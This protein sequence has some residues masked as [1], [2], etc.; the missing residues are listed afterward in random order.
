MRIYK[1]EPDE[2]LFHYCSA[3]TLMAVL[4]SGT[5]RFSDINMMNDSEEARWG[6]KVFEAAATRLIKRQDVG[7]D[8]PVMPK[9]FFDKVDEV[10]HAI[11]LIAHPFIA[12]FSRDADSLEQWRAYGDDG[13]GFVIGFSAKQLAQLPGTMFSVIY[14]VEDQV[15]EMMATLSVLFNDYQKLEAGG[16]VHAFRLLCADLGTMLCGLKHPS[17]KAE[18][19]VRCVHAIELQKTAKGGRRFVDPG[20]TRNGIEHKGEPVGF[21]VRDG[22]LTAY[23]DLP[24][25]TGDVSPV[26]AVI[27]GPKNHSAPGNLLLYLASVGLDAIKFGRSDIPY[28]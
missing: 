8:V 27:I 20:G 22:H 3:Q 16:D 15:R 12:C 21:Y 11:Q 18:N 6:Y 14:D 4:G 28:R 9:D 25:Q 23:V 1:P 5:I 26:E 19:E 24:M 10:V 17:F 2:M 13:R 7:D